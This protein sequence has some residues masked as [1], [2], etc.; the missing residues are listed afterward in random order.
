MKR[1]QID[2][3]RR[4]AAAARQEMREEKKPKQAAAGPA[5]SM[6]LRTAA[7]LQRALSN[8]DDGMFWDYGPA[9]AQRAGRSA[10]SMCLLSAVCMR[11]QWLTPTDWVWLTSSFVNRIQCSGTEKSELGL[12]QSA[13]VLGSMRACKP[14]ALQVMATPQHQHLP[15]PLRLS[16][17][18]RQHS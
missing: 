6:A 15:L 18:S 4:A 9:G 1:E 16:Q 10:V 2:E 13:L 11:W 14:N 8:D 12:L 5:P 17:A 3:Q 7:S